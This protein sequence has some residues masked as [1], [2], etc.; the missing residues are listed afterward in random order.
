MDAKVG[1]ARRSTPGRR[2]D[3]KAAARNGQNGAGSTR[4]EAAEL[5]LDEA[6]LS[7]LRDDAI[8]HV[9]ISFAADK[10]VGQAECEDAAQDALIALLAAVRAGQT[11]RSP[12]AYVKQVAWRAANKA[13]SQQRFVVP[14]AEAEAEPAVPSPEDSMLD[15]VA[16]ARGLAA[17]AQFEPEE[18]AMYREHVYEE[19]SVRDLARRYHKPRATVGRVV[20]QVAVAAT[21]A[22]HS[23]RIPRQLA[24]QLTSFALGVSSGR[25]R[26]TWS[27]SSVTTPRPPRSSARSS[28][29]TRMSLP[30]SRSPSA[31]SRRRTVSL[32]DRGV[33]VLDRLRDRLPGGGTELETVASQAPSARGAGAV[34]GGVGAK[35]AGLSLAGKAALGC[36]GAAAAATA[37]VAAGIVPAAHLPDVGGEDKRA[38]E[39]PAHKQVSAPVAPA[40]PVRA[41]PS[42][43]GDEGPATADAGSDV[44]STAEAPDTSL[45]QS[46]PPPD[47][48][49]Q[50]FGLA[51]EPSPSSTSSTGASASSSGATSSPAPSARSG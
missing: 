46:A 5:L 6:A 10:G 1:D 21:E 41:L 39:R 18:Q 34:A 36:V 44:Q 31:P 40:P 2:R 30:R 42:V 3:T 22:V 47:P 9:R 49:D 23:N 33:A 19:L 29:P 37:C 32:V 26:R 14:A 45:E 12:R 25:E 13:R 15:R 24:D 27:A 35:L 7:A 17:V 16:L 48:V 8:R 38:I 51:P 50:E 11:I 28:G 43:V 4:A 20:R